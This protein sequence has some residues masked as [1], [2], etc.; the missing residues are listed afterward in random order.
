MLCSALRWRRDRWRDW[1]RWA[2]RVGRR[3]IAG[4]DVGDDGRRRGIVAGVVLGLVCVRSPTP[5]TA[6]PT[7]SK[8]TEQPPTPKVGADTVLV[9]V[10]A[11][12]VNPVD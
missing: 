7:S 1:Q 5:A 8:L 4:C 3:A 9:R 2:G 11:A 12:S 10:R 6:A